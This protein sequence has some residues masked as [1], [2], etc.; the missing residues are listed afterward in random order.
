MSQWRY[1]AHIPQSGTVKYCVHTFTLVLGLH[2]RQ[3]TA[4]CGAGVH[5][6]SLFGFAA[7]ADGAPKPLVAAAPKPPDAAGCPKPPV[8][9][10]AP[11]PPVAAAPKPPDA[12]APKP[13][14]AGAPNP[15]AAG[16]PNPPAPG[17]AAPCT[18]HPAVRGKR[19][20]GVGT[21]ARTNA[22]PPNMLATSNSSYRPIM[23]RPFNLLP[24]MELR[25]HL[26]RLSR[27]P[28]HMSCKPPP[29]FWASE[30]VFRDAHAPLQ[31]GFF[32]LLFLF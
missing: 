3:E 2:L 5:S 31:F 18:G 17:A 27:F 26:S 19:G 20:G 22:P 23:W 10:G 8:A 32:R 14:A 11:N 12:A 16:A 13:P 9:A 1:N 29:Y 4:S 30:W 6:L 28:H 7:A 25:L 21:G 15:P 24:A